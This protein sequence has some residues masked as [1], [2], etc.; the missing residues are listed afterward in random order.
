MGVGGSGLDFTCTY[1]R[2]S[3]AADLQGGDCQSGGCLEERIV[4][5]EK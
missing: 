4:L 5:Q 2:F 3:G 1:S